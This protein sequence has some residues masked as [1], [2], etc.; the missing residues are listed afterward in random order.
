[1]GKAAKMSS[2]CVLLIQQLIDKLLVLLTR[3]T[4]IVVTA[5]VCVCVYRHVN[6]NLHRDE[7]KKSSGKANYNQVTLGY[8]KLQVTDR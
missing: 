3:L 6:N 8:R 1:M 7:S 2:F 4:S 5:C